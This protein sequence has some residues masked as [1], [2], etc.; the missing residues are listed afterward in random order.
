MVWMY[1]QS[2]G[3]QT[4]HF[5]L[6]IAFKSFS[7]NIKC[8]MYSVKCCW[9]DINFYTNYVPKYISRQTNKQ[10]QFKNVLT[11]FAFLFNQLISSC[12]QRAVFHQKRVPKLFPL[13]HLSDSTTIG[14]TQIF[15]IKIVASHKNWT[16]NNKT[17]L[18]NKIRY[19]YSKFAS[20][21]CLCWKFCAQKRPERARGTIL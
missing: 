6:C 15:P 10:N 17:L 5:G 12:A 3:H 2:T 20:Y 19:Y 14:P 16:D 11:V 1:V 18:Q 8:Q 4:I 9:P 13:Q 7:T 21:I